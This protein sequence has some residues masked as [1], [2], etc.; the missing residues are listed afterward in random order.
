MTQSNGGAL[1]LLARWMV[2]SLCLSIIGHTMMDTAA[3]L[4]GHTLISWSFVVRTGW[5]AVGIFVALAAWHGIRWVFKNG[6]EL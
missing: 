6:G 2:A 4:P 3:P 1:K 5:D